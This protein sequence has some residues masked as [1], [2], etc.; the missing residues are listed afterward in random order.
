MQAIRDAFP[1]LAAR[2]ALGSAARFKAL[3]VARGLHD[4]WVVIQKLKQVSGRQDIEKV[5]LR[6][7]WS[8]RDIISRLGSLFFDPQA[9]ARSS[10]ESR[11]RL[12]SLANVPN[13]NDLSFRQ[14]LDQATP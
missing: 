10:R 13:V 6:E 14:A 2:F 8:L 12:G 7:V 9:L 1:V 3:Y 11:G 4:A 5:D